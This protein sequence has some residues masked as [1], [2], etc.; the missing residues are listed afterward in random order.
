M[1]TAIAAGGPQVPKPPVA[2]ADCFRN[3][4]LRHVLSR[5]GKGSSDHCPRCSSSAGAKLDP[6]TLEAAASEFFVQ[7]SV[8]PETL[9]PVYQ[10]N[11]LN[12]YPATL[13]PTLAADAELLRTVT[14]LVVFE[15]GPP[16][17]QL[18]HTDH[19]DAFA[20][21]DPASAADAMVR[22]GTATTIHAG[23]ALYRIR[24]NL[25]VGPD[26]LDPATFDPPGDQVARQPGRWDELGSPVLYVSDD[27]ELCL[28]ECRVAL[29]DEIVLVTLVA[30]RDLRLLDL[31]QG[32]A[33]TGPTRFGD[34]ALFADFMS[35]SR[36]EDWLGIC[37]AMAA[38]ARRAGYDGLRY[39]SYY[40]FAMDAGAG[41]NLALFG[42]P[43]AERTLSLRSVNRVRLTAISYG[44]ALGPALY[45]DGA[46]ETA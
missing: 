29:S 10:V 9:A 8:A 38:A 3:D 46:G 2:C 21:G 42:R 45:Q 11:R 43:L 26:V 30:A 40:S 13:D 16:L 7:G 6:D 35:R 36:R 32:L 24:R 19:Y 5:Y 20:E 33:T 18:G 17:W 22:G 12:P 41:L 44:Y 14:G 4:G 23:T 15:Y 37:R 25:A 1:P 34:G 39:S 27:V 31:S 28:H